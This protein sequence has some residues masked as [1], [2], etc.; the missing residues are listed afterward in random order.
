[1]YSYFIIF[2][3][4]FG[5]VSFFFIFRQSTSMHPWLSWN[6][7]CR[8]DWPWTHIVLP[9]FSSWILGL[10]VCIHYY[11]YSI[12]I[13]HTNPSSHFFPYSCSFYLPSPTGP[14]IHSTE[15]VRSPMGE[16][17]KSSSSLWGR[18]KEFPAIC[19]LRQ[20]H[21]SFPVAP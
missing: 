19:S 9:A 11:Y 6:F 14:T 7:V 12:E 2:L 16:S 8:T 3:F 13:L 17:T 15:R 20:G 18:I 1:M 10:K 21:W 4:L 5:F